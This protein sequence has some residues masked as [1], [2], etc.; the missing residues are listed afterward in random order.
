M[1]YSSILIKMMELNL[2]LET[3]AVINFKIDF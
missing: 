3:Y 2:E 1:S